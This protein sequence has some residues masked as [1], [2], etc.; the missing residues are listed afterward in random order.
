MWTSTS[1]QSSFSKPLPLPQLRLSIECRSERIGEYSREVPCFS[2]SGWYTCPEWVAPSSGLS[3]RL[4]GARDKPPAFR[5]R[6]LTD[7]S[8]F[9]MCTLSKRAA[10]E[11]LT[12][13]QPLYH[14]M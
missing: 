7:S 3:S 14:T 10:A 12:P 11:F 13:H 2:C 6:Y 1:L 5:R 8:S 4:F 9:K